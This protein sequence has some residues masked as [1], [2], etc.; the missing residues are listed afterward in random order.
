MDNNLYYRD[1]WAEIHLDA[2]AE[3]VKAMKE[4]YDFKEMNI[5][6]VVKANGYGHG[7]IQV[8]KTAI[9]AG[10]SHLGVALLEEGIELRKAGISSP[11][12]MMGRIR[13]SDVAVAQKHQITITVFQSAWVKEASK[14]LMKELPLYVHLK[15]DTGMGRL[16]LRNSAD[17]QETC[18]LLGK[19]DTFHID[20]VFTHFA[21]ADEKETDYFNKQYRRFEEML[22][23]LQENRVDVANILIHCGNS[24]TGLKYPDK[25]FNLF[26]FGISMYGLTPSPEMTNEL[27]IQLKQ[28]FVLKSKLTHVKKLKSGES[29]SY[30]ATYTTMEEEWIGTIPIGYADGWIR[31][32]STNEGFILINGEKA[33]FV[34]RICMDQCMVKLPREFAVDTEVTLIGQTLPL[35]MDVVAARLDTINYEIPC[36]ITDRVP[37]VYFKNGKYVQ[38]LT[39]Y[40][41]NEQN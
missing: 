13:P 24:A 37:R 25:T 18:S 20:G 21:T 17:I 34:G 22:G 11:I 36:I 2:I 5:M 30:G 32:N 40:D 12:L 33:P 3:N 28:A 19:N 23:W 38:T 10:A 35:N 6:A 15:L 14:H 7:A 31:A 4:F 39:K 1:T 9:E 27:P 16:G 29:I 8:A 26:R 41:K